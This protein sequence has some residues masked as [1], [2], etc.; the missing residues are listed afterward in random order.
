[1]K[2]KSRKQK[3]EEYDQK[4]SHIPINYGERLA[5]LYDYLHITPREAQNIL[6]HRDRMI[7]SLRYFDMNIILFEVPEGSPRPRFRIV[8]RS[9]L[10]NMALSNPNFVH[11][12]SITGAE[13]NSYMHR[14]VADELITLDHLVCT[15]C[16]IEINAF[17]KTP[18]YYNKTSMIM[19]EIGLDRPLSKPD[20]DNIEK[21]YS[22]M[23]NRNVWLDDTFVVDGHIHKYYSILPRVEIRL[24]YL[25]MVYNK[26]Q[27]NQITR[28]KD[29]DSDIDLN[30]FNMEDQ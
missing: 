16:D 23:F 24:R 1:M 9:N 12:Y 6:Q 26:Y 29:F 5:Y 15:P 18:S 27:Y 8:N 25:N 14:L 28:R 4:Y 19:A 20:W 21:K 2:Y 11:V 3:Q 17:V 7:Q 13:D 30:Y 10:S 22:D